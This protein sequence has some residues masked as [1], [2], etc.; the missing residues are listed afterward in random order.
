MLEEKRIYIGNRYVP[1]IMG[2]WSQTIN[3]EGLS[4][5][6]YEGNSYTSKK[7][8]PS[9]IN[10]LNEEFWVVTGNY[11]VQIEQYREDVNNV[12]DS[13]IE[14]T[15]NS[16]QTNILL[17]KLK[18]SLAISL[19]DFPRLTNETS[20]D[21][22]FNRAIASLRTIDYPNIGWGSGTIDFLSV[23]KED[24]VLTTTILIPAHFVMIGI[25]MP[26]IEQKTSG[27]SHFSTD[28]NKNFSLNNIL[29]KG[30]SFFKGKHAFYFGN[31]NEDNSQIFIERCQF[32]KTTD[33]AIYT[34]SDYADKHQS[35]QMKIEK[36]KFM[37]CN[38]VLFNVCDVAVIDFSWFYIDKETLLSNRAV[39]VNLVPQRRL[40]IINSVGVP[41][42]GTLTNRT[43][44]VRWIDNY[45]HIR[46]YNTRFGGEDNG[47]PIV[48]QYTG[49]DPSE[50]KMNLDS[51]II[52]HDG[53]LSAGDAP[54]TG[55]VQVEDSGVV[56]FMNGKIPSV[57]SIERNSYINSVPYLSAP[58]SFDLSAYLLAFKGKTSWFNITVKQNGNVNTDV[59]ALNMYQWPRILNRIVNK[60][61]NNY[62]GLI[63]KS[64]VAQGTGNNSGIFYIDF[65][66]KIVDEIA[67]SKLNFYGDPV[68]PTDI[69]LTK[70]NDQL[71]Y[72]TFK[73]TSFATATQK[74][75]TIEF[76]LT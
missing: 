71:F 21:G 51:S 52:L 24:L 68:Q 36:C 34:F 12:K 74:V 62:E 75:G 32:H 25:G 45:G 22:R 41:T 19:S 54:Y 7:R 53:H 28:M 37:N 26:T 47:I 72:V 43:P 64:F 58:S 16:L 17:E 40:T 57:I 2:E 76:L 8:V 31:H 1:E 73:Q 38:G 70:V 56:R 11:N 46:T 5:V 33:Y 29:I 23:P 30:I 65:G 69:L 59:P 6:T 39:F 67:I 63:T 20:D 18:G 61:D 15:Q 66:F 48:F 50:S 14:L 42:M 60:A 3:Y 13:F 10:I 55:G 44:K 35:T 27:I 49:N 4:I 9:G